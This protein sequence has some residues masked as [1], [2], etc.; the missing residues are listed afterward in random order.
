MFS[1]KNLTYV[2]T[3]LEAIEKVLFYTEEFEDEESFFQANRQLNFNATTNLLIAIG[4]ESLVWD[5]IKNYLPVLKK[6]LIAMLPQI[7]N[8]DKYLKE[9]LKSPYYEELKYLMDL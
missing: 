9:A 3:M 6:L 8:S 7:E 5:V 4:E 1:S 2:L